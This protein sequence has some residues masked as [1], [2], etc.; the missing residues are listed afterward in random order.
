MLTLLTVPANNERGPQYIEKALAAIHQS[1]LRRQT[2]KLVYGSLSG[3]IGLFVDCHST[4]QEAVL[5]PIAANYPQCSVTTVEDEGEIAGWRSW[6]SDL[7]LVPEL[8]PI[9]RHAQFEDLLNRNFAD[10]TSSLL[11]AIK[12]DEQ[13]RCQVEITCAPASHRRYHAARNAVRLLDREFFRRHHQLAFYF[14]RRITRP[15]HF[16]AWLLG[17]I[18]RTTA[19]PM[20]STLE[21]STSRLHE[22]EEDLQ[23]ASD[24]MGGHLFE[25]SIR[26][27][28]QAP[29]VQEQAALDRLRSMTGALGAFT[30]SRLAT[31]RATDARCGKPATFRQPRFLLSHEELAT[32]WHPPTATAGAERMMSSEF[33]ELEAP[34]MIHSEEEP[35]MI[36]L[37]RIRFR[38]DRRSIGLVLEDRRRHVYIVG[39]TGMG[40]TTLM[41][42]MIVADIQ[43]GRG[44]CLVDPHGD[45]AESILGLIPSH[46]TNDVIYFDAASRDFAI[47]FN[48]LACADPA[49][50]DQVTSGVVS[51]F[52][53]L[54]ESW[55][56]RL[57]D[58]L[59]NA[60]F[61]TVEQGG[62]LLSVMRLLGEKGYREQVV[63]KIRDDIVR[64]FWL[65]EFARWSDNY[66]TEAVAAIQNKIRPFL[67]STNIRAIVSQPGRSI[68]LRRIMDDGQVLI[69]NLSKGRVGE[70]NST[71][72]GALL[73]TSIQQ[74]AMT[75]AD[76]PE[77]SRRDFYLYVDEFQNFTTGS[78][79]SVL[80]EARKFRLALTVAHQYLG[81]LSE[82][83][84]GAIWGNVGSI[85]TF[86]VGSDDA[87]VVAQQL[88]KF[89]EQ[90]VP[91]NLTG[92]PK[93]IAYARLLI[94]GMPSSPFSMQPLPPPTHEFDAERAE[95]IRRVTR[96]RFT[97]DESSARGS[98][99]S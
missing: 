49:R 21:T 41:Q 38:D 96:R 87:E 15:G 55:G 28:V 11:R 7:E 1:R 67:T 2:I 82:E 45:L 37:G 27:I 81:Q 91:E 20:H 62:N 26:L 44:V 93:Y 65:H 68:D 94:D 12:P 84:A 52:K 83:T 98:V 5:G 78:F 39:K 17:L 25:T 90:V 40:K 53:K 33:T 30:R 77:A 3:Q 9:L 75:R 92:L 14:A 95:I 76:I 97:V 70:D 10:P 60:V 23:S 74:A 73:V 59:R 57:E 85:I 72:L 22:R 24:K 69:V 99:V 6:F 13:L 80:S 89:P 42:N 63:S 19:G 54:N 4:V 48:P 18:A 79:A 16:V 8:F 58:T 86:Q 50:I 35:G 47:G 31:F 29:P 51:A 36:V 56:P 64:S 88:S 61:A 34:A 66:R 46:R 43:A 32:L 71:L